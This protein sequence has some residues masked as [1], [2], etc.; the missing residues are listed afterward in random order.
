MLSDNLVNC[1]KK[2]QQMEFVSDNSAPLQM[3]HSSYKSGP[4]D[5]PDDPPIDGGEDEQ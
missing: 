1:S 2:G 5:K 3:R 4:P